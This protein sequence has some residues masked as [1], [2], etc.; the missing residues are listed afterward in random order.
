[1]YSGVISKFTDALKK[2]EI[3]IIFGDGKQTRDFVYVKDVVQG[4]LL[5]MHSDQVGHGDAFNI[6]T[7]KTTDL[8]TLL[9]TINEILGLNIQPTFKEMRAGDIRHSYASIEKAKELLG[10][11]PKFSL[12]EGLKEL[13]DYTGSSVS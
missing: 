4:N 13:L 7:N 10:Y 11:S 3:P 2:Q 9:T 6:A 1:M 8:L 5:A 12:K